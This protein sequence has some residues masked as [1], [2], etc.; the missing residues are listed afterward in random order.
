MEKLALPSFEPSDSFFA[1][2]FFTFVCKVEY[3]TNIFIFTTPTKEKKR[4]REASPGRLKRMNCWQ[5][6]DSYEGEE[7]FERSES[8]SGSNEWI[9][10]RIMTSTKEKKRSREASSG[11]LKRRNSWQDNGFFE[12]FERREP[13]G[14]GVSS[15]KNPQKKAVRYPSFPR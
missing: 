8:G 7:A 13:G 15:R 2:T 9:P 10:D 5:D 14:L 4:S 11:R 6:N 12:S 1:R 3:M